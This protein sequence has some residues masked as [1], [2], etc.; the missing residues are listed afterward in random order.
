MPLD[1]RSILGPDGAAARRL[2]RYEVRDEQ[3]RMTDAVARAI[4]QG[5]HL[6][7]EAGTGVG[8]SFAYLVPAIMAAVEQK[9]KVV[10]STHTIALQEQL[11]Q[12]DVPFLRSI[13]PQEFTAVLVKGRGNYISLRRLDGA[14]A[15]A[16]ST[17]N[18]PEEYD[19]LAEMKMWAGKTQ[20]GTRSDL[21]FKPLHSVWD[22]VQSENGNCLGKQCPRYKDCFYFQARR[23]VWTAN[24][25][26]VNHAL[27]V[28]DLAMRS[29]GYGL[30][31]EYDVA[32]FDEAHTL[33]AVAGEHLGIQFS[34]IGLDYSLARL[35]NERTGK[36]ILAGL[37]L[38]DAMAQ[39][40]RVR[41]AAEDFFDQVSQWHTR[42]SSP[43]A[44]VRRPIE[45]T[46]ALA[47]ELKKL[48]TAIDYGAETIE[49]ADQLVELSAA[50][51]RCEMLSEEVRTWVRQAVEGQVYW[52][53]AEAGARRRVKLASAPLDVGP[54]LRRTLF[55][56]VPTCVLTSATLCVGSP[57]KFDFFKSRVGLT[58]AETLAL[59]S[60]FDYPNQV[61]IHLARNLPDPST[62]PQNFE[63]EVIG[64]IAHYLERTQ[65][66]AF[67]LFTSYKMLEAAARAL[68]PWLAERNIAL[69]AQSDGMPRS[70]MVEAF[71]SDLNSVIFGA[72]S[73][74][75]GV[76]VPGEA[77]SNVIIVRLPFSVPTHPLLEARLEDIRRRGGNPFVEYQI[78]EAV[79]KL[80]QGFGRLIRTR[81]DRGIVAILDPRVLTKPYG[82]TFL[83][84]LPECPR[85]VD[86][87]N[88]AN[89]STAAK[90]R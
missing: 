55:E 71:K 20:D 74:W 33:E 49:S 47:E 57:P 34:N 1:P 81:T 69:F 83:N 66:K 26:I 35:Y 62:D 70:K 77:L 25:L 28:S 65:G 39:V 56:K 64:A 58:R 80:K 11:L 29:A 27:F 17:F 61:K 67:V 38:G 37:K 8:K 72:D 51:D 89:P 22:A 31:P 40:R 75:Q 78:P 53:E 44:R 45:V 4:D 88:F 16:G 79:I 86:P 32:I 36:G 48:S 7:V 60:P 19:Q 84:S 30:L 23:R 42:Q 13:M 90:R 54:T 85:I 59:G 10:V 43:T 14:A 9:K 5:G 76:D 52:V 82:K 63:R 46:D 15:R 6:V 3:L 21:D 68:T 50:S 41:T 24:I 18:R 12:K 87:D 73:F 2:P